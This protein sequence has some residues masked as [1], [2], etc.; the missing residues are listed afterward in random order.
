MTL[1]KSLL[2]GVATGARSFSAA[3]MCAR[4]EPGPA[5]LD[6]FLHRR[7]VRRSLRRSALLEIAGDKLPVTPA[8]TDRAGLVARAV[9][10]A[11]TGG[12]VAA[13]G[14]EP[15][16]RGALAGLAGAVAWS[17]TG[18]RVRAMAAER[19][20]RDLPGAVAEDVAAYALAFAA[21]R[22]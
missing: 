4:T 3:A 11:T 10:G 14:N 8:R 18:V 16:W 20:G 21:T 22:R 2:A 19:A 13:R 9:L 5:R 17:Y 1:A 15:A 6:R 12:I 7:F